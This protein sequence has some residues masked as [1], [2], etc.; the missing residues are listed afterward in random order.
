MRTIR[1]LYYTKNNNG[2]YNYYEK[3]NAPRD[4]KV[5][6]YRQGKTIKII[7]KDGSIKI[8]YLY[9]EKQWSYDEEE[10]RQHREEQAKLRTANAN[11]NAML[12]EIMDYYKTLSDE[13]LKNFLNK[14]DK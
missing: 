11:R 2:T 10:I 5:V 1:D 14:L 9:G 8:G 12:K 3:E 6:L 4:A 13:E 7:Q